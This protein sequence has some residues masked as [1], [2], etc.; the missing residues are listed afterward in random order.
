LR[1]GVLKK[2]VEDLEGLEGHSDIAVFIT[3]SCK[4]T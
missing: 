1:G 2:G 4:S 3:H